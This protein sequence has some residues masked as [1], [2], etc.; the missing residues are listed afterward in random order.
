MLQSM[1][2]AIYPPQCVLCGALTLEDFAL[3]GACWSDCPFISDLVC[4]SCGLPLAGESRGH[5]E[6]CDACLAAPRPWVRGRAVM[7]YAGRGRDLVLGLKH[8]DR[9]D[10]ARPLGAWMARL[11]PDLCDGAADPLLVPV[12]LHPLR[13]W[14]RRYNQ[15]ALLAQSIGRVTGVGVLP[16]GLRR[17]KR[18][19]KLQALG[20]GARHAALKGAFALHPRH[21]GRIGGRHLVVVD[22]VMTSGATLS[23]ATE[24]LLAGGAA[25]VRVLVL[26]RTEKAP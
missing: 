11:L 6:Y 17:V 3:C 1:I 8:G 22:D 16:D 21:A 26:A 7:L 10:L 23:V 18:T 19:A 2:R 9:S 15:A 20:V 13:L 14:R 12:P 5:A 4:E 25:S 24:T